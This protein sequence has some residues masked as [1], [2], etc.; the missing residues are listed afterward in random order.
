MTY[1]LCPEDAVDDGAVYTVTDPDDNDILL[2]FD[3]ETDAERY[4]LFLE[5]AGEDPYKVIEVEKD[6]VIDLCEIQGYTYS[7]VTKDTLVLPIEIK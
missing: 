3:E 6:I 1:I 5:E 2:I 4:S 7:I